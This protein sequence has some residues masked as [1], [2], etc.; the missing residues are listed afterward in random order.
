MS[1]ANLKS[2]KFH[3]AVEQWFTESY[4]GPTDCQAGAWPAIQSGRDVL[5]AAPTGSG[6]TLAAFLAAID[7]LVKIGLSEGGLA[8]ETRIVYI[9][10]LKALSYDIERNLEAPLQGIRRHLIEGGFPDVDIRT[11]V[12]TG[13]TTQSERQKM[14]RNPPHVL[15]TTP[16]SLYLLLTAESGRRMLHCAKRL[17]VDEIHSLAGNKRGAHFSLS[18]TRLEVL[19]GRPLVK[20]GLSAT[21][22]PVERVASYLTGKTAHACTIVD[23]GHV[24]EWDLSIEVPT[25]PLESVMSTESWLEVYQIIANLVLRHRTTLIFVNTRRHAE[26]ATR[27]LAELLGEENVATH[28]GSLSKENRHD[29]EQRLKSGSLRALV[30][31]A[32]LELGIDIGEV[33]LV[34]Q[35]CSP[36]SVAVFLQRV[37]RSGH[38]VGR[39]PK[40]RLFPTT[41]DELVESAALLNAIKDGEMEILEICSGSIDVLAQQIVAEASVRDCGIDDLF[42]I[43]RQAYPYRELDQERYELL[44]QMLS[45]GFT[46]RRGRR[47]AYIHLDAVNRV[48]KGRKGAR[49][50]AATNCGAIPDMFDYDVILEPDEIRIGTVNEDFAFESLAGDIFQL[51]NASYRIL[52][53]DKGYV[54]VEDAQGLP[55]NIPFWLGEGRGRSTALSEAVSNLRETASAYL[56]D[57]PLDKVVDSFCKE[58]SLD[59][60]VATQIVEYLAAALKTLGVL[61]SRETVVFERFFD[62]TGDTHLVVHSV[63]GS[64]LNRAWGLALRKRFCVRFNFELQAAA[65]EDTFVLSLGPTHSFALDEVQGYVRK[66]S[67]RDTLVQAIFGAPMFPTRWRWVA[68]TALAV[69]R[70][71]NGKKVP[72][73]LQRN[74]AED[75]LALVF[76]DQV[77]CQENITGPI[78]VP[79]HPLVQQTINDCLQEVMDANALEEL[80]QRIEDGEV[81]IV[82]RDLPEPSPLAH[83]VLTAKP[84]AFL[85]DAP[86]E[87]RRTLAVQSRRLNETAVGGELGRLDPDAIDFLCRQ[88][89]PA[90][91]NVDELHDALMILGYL[92]V[93][94]ARPVNS[95]SGLFNVNA[96]DTRWQTYFDQLATTERATKFRTSNLTEFWVAAERLCEMQLLHPD[97]ELCPVIDPAGLRRKTVETPEQAIV[98]VLRG[99]LEIVGPCTAN[100]LA[101]SFDLPVSMVDTALLAL[102]SEGSAMRGSFASDGQEIEWCDRRF[103]ARI[104]KRTITRLR[105]EITPVDTGGYMNY[106]VQWFRLCPETQGEGPD[107]LNSI[108]HQME[109]YEALAG[110]WESDILPSRVFGYS[111]EMLDYLSASGKIVWTRLS[112]SNHVTPEPGQHNGKRFFRSSIRSVPFAFLVRNRLPVWRALT[113]DVDSAVSRLSPLAALIADAL[114]EHGALFFDEILEET[115]QLP[116]HGEEGLVELFALGIATCDHFG[117]IRALLMPERERRNRI[118][119]GRVLNRSVQ[120]SGRWSLL[121]KP[122]RSTGES[123]SRDEVVEY[124]VAT[125]LRR[126][127]ILFRSLLAKE[128]KYFPTWFEVRRVCRRMEDRGELRGGRFVSGVPGEQFAL[129]QAVKMLRDTRKLNVGNRAVTV[130]ASDPLNL[131]GVVGSDARVAAFA[132]NYLVYKDGKCITVVESGRSR[133]TAAVEPVVD[134]IHDA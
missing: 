131:T 69:V 101:S 28:H 1:E 36:R 63:Y 48:V 92:R 128:G 102:E 113:N 116:T 30:A 120:E 94:E 132:N 110:T 32:S 81:E 34:C 108:L 47:G 12:R 53:V 89:W 16:E 76:P 90:P 123:L 75:L 124:A 60:F 100:Q 37:G 70:N 104:H 3:D 98:S 29:T 15:V 5:I 31:T 24:R 99:R 117:G 11:A 80:I 122:S 105:N 91:T 111:P 54:R 85:D 27:Y 8:Q 88:A 134:S 86:A 79:D 83:E 49:I 106:L 77:A 109:G 21:Q 40:G 7:E 2:W 127:G 121:D 118:R 39:I 44:L 52:R 41:R 68:N 71:R 6:K 43:F 9:S 58:Y 10:P 4:Q 115:N 50:V 56:A 96:P 38:A 65:L 45:E 59:R 42:R 23:S 25:A 112:R 82:C 66:A 97:S 84:Y 119:A 73:P 129:P 72:P 57:R 14:A 95:N 33:D 13:D 55:P 67:V 20:V 64:R 62:E 22:K 114:R 78:E 74:D 26:R 19:T 107:V 51:G 18:V 103:L 17:I 87:E 35:I 125:L 61:P 126:Y 93:D 130:H 133:S 46:L